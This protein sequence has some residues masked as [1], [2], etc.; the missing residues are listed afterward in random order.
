MALR[1]HVL[2]R[3]IVL[4]MN[5]RIVE[6]PHVNRVGADQPDLLGRRPR[7][8][9][10]PALNVRASIRNTYHRLLLPIGNEKFRSERQARMRRRVLVRPVGL[11]TRRRCPFKLGTVPTAHHRLGFSLLANRSHSHKRS[12]S[13]HH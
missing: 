13:P 10:A 7:Q 8:I 6:D 4:V 9:Y 5:I 2:F 11:P 1:G 12:Y 3:K